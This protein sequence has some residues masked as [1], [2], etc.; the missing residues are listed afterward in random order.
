GLMRQTL[1]YATPL[2]IEKS[3]CRAFPILDNAR[4]LLREA[5]AASGTEVTVDVQPRGLVLSGAQA[6]LEDVIVNL[7]G[8]ALEAL[9]DG[10]QIR[11]AA[12]YHSTSEVCLSVEDDGPGVRPGVKT[13]IFKPFVTTKPEGTGLG[14][15]ICQKVVD[16][17]QGRLE[18]DSSPLG[19]ARFSIYL[20]N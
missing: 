6:H 10:G 19:G 12:R 16:A 18:L 2:T 8:N 5:L 17:H 7:L 20:P 14:L 15:A 13:T 3:T 4:L 9:E 1:S 11:L